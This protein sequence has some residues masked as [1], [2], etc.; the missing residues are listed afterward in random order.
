MPEERAL[1]YCAGG[2]IGDSLLATLVGRALQKRFKHIDVL[3]LPAHREA[4]EHVE[5]I[6]RVA[7][8]AG[9]DEPALARRLAHKKYA[10]CIVS[11]A[12]PRTARIPHAAR[13]PIRVGQ[14][15]R[16]YSWRFTHRVTVRSEIGDITTHW[17]QI[18]LDYARALG[19]DTDETVPSFIPSAADREE[20]DGLLARLGL[21]P[22]SYSML[23]PANAVASQRGIW[24]LEGWIAL[25]AFIRR[26]FGTP[27]LVTGS[28][29][30][31]A[32]AEA[33]ASSAGA[34]S[35][36]GH[37]TIGAFAAVAQN[38]RF[39]TGI[40]TGSMHIAAAVGARTVGIFPFQSDTP[41]R[42]APLGPHT[43][44]VRATYPCRNGERKETCPDY[45][46]VAHLDVERVI[47]AMESLE[48]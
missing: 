12:T 45:A 40:T 32:I 14:D 16:L 36:A 19:C 5:G 48:A 28:E 21:A 11:W 26:R 37:T 25:T 34:L 30:D 3:T 44:I 18:L 41:E 9:E 47:A 27:V 24:P 33:I 7:V 43:A 35:I 39:F 29:E 8:D 23:H 17:S 31:R 20:A 22:A 2:G 13:I 46:C 38:A 4:L 1:L 42:W 6:D 15:R 10:A